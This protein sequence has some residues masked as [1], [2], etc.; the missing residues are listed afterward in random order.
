ME[1]RRNSIKLRCHRCGNQWVYRGNNF[2]YASCS[3]C[4]TSVKIKENTT[5]SYCMVG[6]PN[7]KIES[8]SN[9]RPNFRKI[10]TETPCLGVCQTF[11]KQSQEYDY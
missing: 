11:L 4:K 10:V 8:I 1:I 2:F 7:N 5:Q 3:T 6:Q 9:S